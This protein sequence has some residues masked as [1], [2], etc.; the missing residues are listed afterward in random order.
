MP[1]EIELHAAQVEK[2]R[3]KILFHFILLLTPGLDGG[4]QRAPVYN[5]NIEVL[6]EAVKVQQIGFK[7]HTKSPSRTGI[8]AN[9]P[10]LSMEL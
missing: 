3:S 8:S 2:G 6:H 9:F 1:G 7:G 10:G 4:D 5:R